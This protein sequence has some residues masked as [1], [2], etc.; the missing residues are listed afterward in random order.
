MSKTEIPQLKRKQVFER[1]KG[2]CQICGKQLTM[3]IEYGEVQA[4]HQVDYYTI[5]HI[6]PVSKGGKNN[7]ENLRILCRTCNCMKH[8]READDFINAIDKNIFKSFEFN[9]KD[10]LLKDYIQLGEKDILINGLKDI[11]AKVLKE[12][13]AHIELINSM[14]V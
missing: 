4:F 13:D 1:D 12:I 7:I 10:L 6:K 8:N 9:N 14:E 11:K 2:K 3:T 5:D